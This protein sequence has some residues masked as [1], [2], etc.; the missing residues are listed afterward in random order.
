MNIAFLTSSDGDTNLAVASIHHLLTDSTPHTC[1]F[2]PMTQT[3]TARVNMLPRNEAVKVTPY[4]D[5]KENFDAFLKQHD[6]NHVY[7]GVPSSDNK[8]PLALAKTL[9]LPYTIAYE[10]M[11]HENNHVFWDDV[12]ALSQSSHCEFAVPLPLASHDVKAHAPNAKVSIVGHLSLDRAME[13]K[14]NLEKIKETRATLGLSEED[15]YVFAS[16]SSQNLERD[17]QFLRA[18]L[19]ELQSNPYPNLKI[20]FGVHP[21]VSDADLYLA[22]LLQVCDELKPNATQ[23]KIVL[24]VP[25][26]NKLKSSYDSPY[27]HEVKVPGPE[28][29]DAADKVTQAVPGAL[30]NEAATLGIPAYFHALETKIYLPKAWF[31]SSVSAFFSAKRGEAHQRAEL[32][33]NDTAPVLMAAYLKN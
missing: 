12:E 27:L 24:N 18:L 10:Y 14:P 15:D 11:F 23:F 9:A 16:G 20:R 32:G 8:E 6:I 21:G 28:A 5:I 25:F 22:N 17:K 3:A 1:H 33:L 4:L 29:A 31:S 2:I 26:A 30:L 13:K 19:T 7:I